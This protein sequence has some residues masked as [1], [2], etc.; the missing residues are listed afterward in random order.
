MHAHAGT[1]V[2]YPLFRDHGSYISIHDTYDLYDKLIT[3]MRAVEMRDAKMCKQNQA[4][5]VLF[6][7]F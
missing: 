2:I 4:T 6:L 3:A 5:N 7:K 1:V